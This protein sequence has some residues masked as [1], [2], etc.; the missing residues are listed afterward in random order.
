M[1]DAFKTIKVNDKEY[2]M[3]FNIN[4]AAVMQKK[5]GSM[6]KFADIL[7]PK[8]GEPSLDDVIFMYRECINE[9]ID[10]ENEDKGEKRSFITDKQA[11]RIMSAMI[12]SA[13]TIKSLIAESNNTGKEKN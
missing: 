5:Y 1:K 13:G 6:Q 8:K 12:D 3:V 2:P 10:V 11:G 9:G 7:S 4:V